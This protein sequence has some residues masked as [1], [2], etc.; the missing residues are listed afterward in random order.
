[1]LLALLLLVP[2]IGSDVRNSFGWP[3]ARA[4]PLVAMAALAF[5]APSFLNLAYSPFRH[6]GVK[7][8]DYT[9]LLAASV[10]HNDL[11]G[12]VVRNNRV[13][14]NIALDGKGSG[15]EDRRELAKRDETLTEFQGEVFA[16]CE[17]QLG[18]VAWFEAIV[19]DLE[20]NGFAGGKAIYAADIFNSHWLFGDVTR[21]K[22]G[23]P[24]YYGGLPGIESADFLL[25]PLCP[26]SVS[27]R[28]QVLEAIGEQGRTLP[29]LH[30][31]SLYVLYD[32][33][34]D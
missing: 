31:T 11:Q 18:I 14:G 32:L 25:V 6:L 28:K 7:A 10:V 15:L 29:E 33:S 23:A 34:A 21:L 4:V 30:R 13:D 9:P 22:G 1:M 12:R 20:V 24:W 27:I 17:L 19:A 5:G 2:E 16:A 3:L 8:E 26:A